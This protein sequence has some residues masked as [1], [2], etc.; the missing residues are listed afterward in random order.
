[1]VALEKKRSTR[2]PNLAEE[3]NNGKLPQITDVL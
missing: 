1:M 2:E 3:V